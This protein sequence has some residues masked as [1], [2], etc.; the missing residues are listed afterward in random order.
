MSTALATLQWEEAWQ[1]YEEGE[2]NRNAFAL[3]AG[4]ADRQP[5]CATFQV[6]AMRSTGV[7]IPKGGDSAYTPTMMAAYKRAGLLVSGAPRPGD[8]GFVY[9]QSL[10][11]IGHVFM[12]RELVNDHLVRT[13]EGNASPEGIRTGG[14]V[15]SLVRD[16]TQ[17]Q[18]AWVAGFVRPTYDGTPVTLANLPAKA[19]RTG[20][21]IIPAALVT[22]PGGDAV[23]V[24][25]GDWGPRTTGA[26]QRALGVEDDEVL[27]PVTIAALQRLLIARVGAPT[28][29][30]GGADGVLAGHTI[31]ALQAYLGTPRDG[32]IS[33]PYSDVVAELQRRLNAGTFVQALAA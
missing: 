30:Q 29:K 5:W 10:G 32:K 16:F 12:V 13:V 27:G 20:A 14:M 9:Y 21:F 6:A 18:S 11:R 24:I 4:H 31:R 1:G 23:L 15:T 17:R 25:D 7:A 28:K 8:L 26:L 2:G 22:H 19:D 33:K 3:M